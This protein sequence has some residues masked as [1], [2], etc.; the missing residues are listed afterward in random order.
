MAKNMVRGECWNAP[1]YVSDNL[2]AVIRLHDK[3][4]TYVIGRHKTADFRLDDI[5][6]S[7]QHGRVHAVYCL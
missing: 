4:Q 5:E 6:V 7:G 3:P 2:N 1:Q